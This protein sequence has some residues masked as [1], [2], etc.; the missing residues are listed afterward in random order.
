M[1]T[2]VKVYGARAKFNATAIES[3]GVGDDDDGGGDG[4]GGGGGGGPPTSCGNTEV[5][6]IGGTFRRRR[7]GLSCN[8]CV[9]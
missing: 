6:G 8:A 7:T 5:S 4:D 3:V 2:I 9:C 1:V